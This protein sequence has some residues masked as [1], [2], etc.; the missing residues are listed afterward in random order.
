[1][2]IRDSS[3]PAHGFAEHVDRLGTDGMAER[4]RV[5]NR[6]RHAVR[7][8]FP[9]CL[10][11][12]RRSCRLNQPT[13]AGPTAQVDGEHVPWRTGIFP[14]SASQAQ[15]AQTGRP[16]TMAAPAPRLRGSTARRLNGAAAPDR[17]WIGTSVL[18]SAGVN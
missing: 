18:Q 6:V 5:T 12:G 17:Q 16:D 10:Q 7:W 1:M 15:P 13:M 9:V 3:Y 2:C 4:P 14:G 11:W 8:A